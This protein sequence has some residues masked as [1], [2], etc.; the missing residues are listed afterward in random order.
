MTR[1]IPS[2]TTV[3][4]A[5]HHSD[6]GKGLSYAATAATLVDP[7]ETQGWDVIDVTLP[8]GSQTSVYSFSVEREPETINVL[9]IDAWADGEDCT[10]CGATPD[11]AHATHWSYGSGMTGCLYD[12]GPGFAETKS[13]AIEAV[14]SSFFDLSEGALACAR[15]GLEQDGIYHFP[16]G[17]CAGA[18]YV[19]VTELDGPCPDDAA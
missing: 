11:D 4:I 17:L 1:T 13:D 5:A 18:D 2:G 6:P 12:G 16:S 3:Q 19:E 9:S 7:C 15:A 14:L 8:D 10:E